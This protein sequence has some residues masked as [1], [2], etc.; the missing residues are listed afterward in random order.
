VVPGTGTSLLPQA[1]DQIAGQAVGVVEMVEV[2]VRQRAPEPRPG[3]HLPAALQEPAEPAF[4]L[5]QQ[6]VR[7]AGVPVL[8]EV[9]EGVHD[10]FLRQVSETARRLAEADSPDVLVTLL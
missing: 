8:P 9:A 1:H 6:P 4:L 5:Q 10:Q 7:G 2:L 3:E